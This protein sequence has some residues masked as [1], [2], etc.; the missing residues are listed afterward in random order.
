VTNMNEQLDDEQICEAVAAALT[1]D[2]LP[3]E[4]QYTGG[5]IW[6]VS[7]TEWV[8]PKASWLC[9]MS[10]E[11]WAG[12]LMDA[13]SYAVYEGSEDGGEM[14]LI[15]TDVSSESQDVAAIAAALA[16]A[17]RTWRGERG[18]DKIYITPQEMAKRVEGV[19]MAAAIDAAT[20]C[21]VIINGIAEEIIAELKARP[22]VLTSYTQSPDSCDFVFVEESASM[23]LIAAGIESPDEEHVRDAGPIAQ[24]A[25]CAPV[26]AWL[27]REHNVQP[28]TWFLK[29]TGAWR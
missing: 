14:Q 24:Q 1:A 23:R 12:T 18:G 21:S 5:G 29:A 22:D 27:L 16:R 20:A 2:G 8:R 17:I 13:D 28:P 3:S 4:A 15:G 11:V 10:C 26:F 6:C 25:A 7:I 9:G 19:V